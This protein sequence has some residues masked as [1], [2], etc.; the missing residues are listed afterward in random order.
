[1]TKQIGI[2]GSGAVGQSLAT[3]LLR[4]GYAVM[5]GSEQA[6]KRVHL[7]QQI[8]GVKTGTFN[9][10]AR[11]GELVILAVK[12]SAATAALSLIEP[13]TLAGKTVIDTTNPIADA[14]PENGVLRYFTS[15]N[16]SLMEQ[17]QQLMPQAHF[18]KCFSCVGSAHMIDPNFG[19]EKPTMF[20]CGNSAEAKQEV[21]ELLHATG[22]E[23]AD[24]GGATSAR[25]IEPLA[26][27]W[28][29]PGF[30]HNRWNQAF[31]LLKRW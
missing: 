27:L 26:M 2:I 13:A 17:L 3:G 11:Y 12:G 24:M 20:I 21:A 28:C 6:E 18:V 9:D 14:P 23:I 25:A 31:R 4:H 16:S 8:P 19:S 15:M 1:M 7:G 10:A 30:Q 29:I 22:W 5:I